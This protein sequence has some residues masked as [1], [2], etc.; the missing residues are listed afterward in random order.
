MR[1]VYQREQAGGYI[2]NR[3]A[4][5]TRRVFGDSLLNNEGPEW[6]RQRRMLK[7]YFMNAAVKQWASLIDRKVGDLADDWERKAGEWIAVDAACAALTQ[8]IMTSV[9][10]GEEVGQTAVAREAIE[11]IHV[12]H[13]EFVPQ[14]LGLALLGPVFSWLPL[15]SNRRFNRAI[16]TID[17][18][19]SRL[20]DQASGTRQGLVALLRE[21]VDPDTGRP[22]D[23][24]L[25]RDV[26]VALYVA[27]QETT[28]IALTWL[29]YE[30][31]KHPDIA[32]KARTEGLNC[33]GAEITAETVPYV[34]AIVQETLRL[35]PSTTALLRYA[36]S[37]DRIGG[38]AIPKGSLVLMSPYVTHRL[39][40]VWQD[41]ERFDPARFA[42]GLN[43]PGVCSFITF[44][45]G[46][47][48]CL[49]LHLAN[50]VLLQS[51]VTL[52]Q[53]FEFRFP[54]GYQLNPRSGLFLR[55]EGGCRIQ[56]VPRLPSDR[57][58]LVA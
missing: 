16:R 51:A 19:I 44:G 3:F 24:K 46:R 25:L 56:V 5:V 12:V 22:M 6:A 50:R 52:L 1:H 29:L 23:T 55:P 58:V 33:K 31:A 17:Q 18:T 36:V 7:P 47:H 53:R 40:D 43:A 20:V 37:D 21:T 11:A 32:E 9:L 49:G 28:G 39:P 42:P 57:L 30:L 48:M 34:W 2:N 8:A 41:P 27:G 35:H 15:P 26:V 14:T 54:E 45:S 38:V 10:F 13:Q 4:S